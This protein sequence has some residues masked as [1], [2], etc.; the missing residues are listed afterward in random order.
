MGYKG[1]DL[2][3]EIKNFI[4]IIKSIKSIAVVIETIDK[5]SKAKEKRL[6]KDYLLEINKTLL[7]AHVENDRHISYNMVANIIR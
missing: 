6:H 4:S 7:S 5:V 3:K 2:S 1:I